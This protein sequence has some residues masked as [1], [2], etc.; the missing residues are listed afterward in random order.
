[1][2]TATTH[3]VGQAKVSSD[4]IM[5]AAVDLQKAA[6]GA[7]RLKLKGT[8]YCGWMRVRLMPQIAQCH[9]TSPTKARFTC[10]RDD[11]GF[12]N[13]AHRFSSR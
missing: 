10:T 6:E 8:K 11:F 9:L 4:A 7:D 13:V 5:D 1:V 2:M 3:A 12:T